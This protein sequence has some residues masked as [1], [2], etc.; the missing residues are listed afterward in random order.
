MFSKED[1][2]FASEFLDKV[3]KKVTAMAPEIGANFP[4]T[5]SRDGIWDPKGEKVNISGWTTAFWPGMM[6]LMYL[7]TGNEMFREYAE[8]CEEKLDEAFDIF[9]SFTSYITFTGAKIIFPCFPSFSTAHFT[10]LRTS[11]GVPFTSTF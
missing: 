7:K 8:G 2:S 1:L 5:I 6:W 10:F 9:T 3:V 11:S 4:T